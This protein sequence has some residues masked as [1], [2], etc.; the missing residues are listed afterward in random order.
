MGVGSIHPAV[1]LALVGLFY[2]LLVGILWWSRHT[3]SG[4]PFDEIAGL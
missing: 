4:E 2:G 3:S 1:V